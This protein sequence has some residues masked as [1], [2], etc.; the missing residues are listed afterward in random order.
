MVPSSY[1]EPQCSQLGH[2]C[3]YLLCLQRG[4][5]VK[6]R[7]TT[8]RSGPDLTHTKA[9]ITQFQRPEALF[10][11][12]NA[13][14]TKGLPWALSWPVFGKYHYCLCLD[15]TNMTEALSLQGK[16]H[17]CT[18]L[19]AQRPRRQIPDFL[20]MSSF[21]KSLRIVNKQCR[22]NP[23]TKGRFSKSSQRKNPY[24]GIKG[25]GGT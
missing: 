22:R 3:S 13:L 14:S 4:N 5:Q 12:P 10:L 15:I 2:V 17:Q 16:P 20:S 18:R 25:L 23:E 1:C 19:L 21:I 8:L 6:A 11:F 9:D 24:L 7:S